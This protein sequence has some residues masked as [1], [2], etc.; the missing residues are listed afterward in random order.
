MS[1]W[2]PLRECEELLES[3][4]D[5]QWRQ[6][7]PRFV[8]GDL[9][10]Q[11]GFVGAGGLTAEVSTA[12]A[13]LVGAEQAYAEFVAAGFPSAGVWAVSVDEVSQV[14]ARAVGDADCEDV[15]TEGHS[16]IDLRGLSKGERRQAR[17]VLATLATTR[18]RQF[19]EGQEA[20]V[21]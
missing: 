18:G 21:R 14:G 9:V 1:D 8:D 7:N 10:S 16:Y 5:L 19:P 13:V 17:A 11:E 15:E 3:P 12:Q 6:V 2:P 4:E 20:E